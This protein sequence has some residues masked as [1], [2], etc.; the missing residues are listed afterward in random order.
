[1]KKLSSHS[2]I[3]KREVYYPTILGWTIIALSLFLMLILY[4]LNIYQFLSPNHPVSAEILIVEGW[5]P[6]YVMEAA[7]SEFNKGDYR[8]I[9]TTGGPL[10][11]GHYLVRY[12]SIARLAAATFREMGVA[13]EKII[14]LPAPFVYKNRTFVAAKE[15]KEWLLKHPDLTRAN[16]L[17]M[18]PHGRRSYLVF[19]KA[20]PEN[21]ELGIIAIDPKD[22][23]PKRWWKT[24]AGARAVIYETIAYLYLLT[25]GVPHT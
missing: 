12:K 21:T 18:G 1:M 4:L 19:K 24:S 16:L 14:I 10:T 2:F 22:Y 20:L 11:T 23:E 6:D 8:Y 5:G 25:F 3:K 7:L 9:L 13:E 15:V 17:T